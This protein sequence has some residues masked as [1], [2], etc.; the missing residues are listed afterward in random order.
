MIIDKLENRHRYQHLH[1]RIAA[2][3]AF[4][5]DTDLSALPKGRHSIDGD[6]LFAIVNDYDTQPAGTE[7]FET[8]KRYADVQFVVSGEEA[9]GYLPLAGQATL[10]PYHEAHDFVE[11]DYQANKDDACF[12]PLKAGMFA[13]FMPEDMHMPGTGEQPVRVRKVVCKVLL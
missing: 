8:H 4:L 6:N 9:F 7:P 1:P 12:I 5:A 11:Y 3:L 13:I 2:A 10:A